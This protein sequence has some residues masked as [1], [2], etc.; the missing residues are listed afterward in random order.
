MIPDILQVDMSTDEASLDK[1]SK[2]IMW[3][4]QIRIVNIPKSAPEIVG[5]FKG[6]KK[7]TDATLFFQLV[8]DDFN[9]ISETGIDF[10]GKTKFLKFRCFIADTPARSFSLGHC[11]YNSKAPCSRCWVRGE[12]IR[13]G[14]MVYRG[15][16]HARRTQDEYLLQ[17]DTDHQQN[18]SYKYLLIEHQMLRALNFFHRTPMFCYILLRL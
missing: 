2:I 4:I 3:P 9:R 12:F 1:A 6:E 13:P 11:G 14:V 15:F 17:V 16:D 8:V 5:I 18:S 10:Q 7:P